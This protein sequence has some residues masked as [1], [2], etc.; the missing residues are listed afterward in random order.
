MSALL[1]ANRSSPEKHDRSTRTKTSEATDVVF[2]D[3]FAI[4]GDKAVMST[5]LDPGARDEADCQGASDAVVDVA[6]ASR[7]GGACRLPGAGLPCRLTGR[8]HPDPASPLRGDVPAGAEPAGRVYANRLSAALVDRSPCRLESHVAGHTL[9]PCRGGKRG[10][11]SARRGSSAGKKETLL[12]ASSPDPAGAMV[13]L[14]VTVPPDFSQADLA[15]ATPSD[16]KEME[17]AL[18]KQ[19][20]KLEGSGGPTII[21]MQRARFETMGGRRALVI[22]YRRSSLAGPSPG[23]SFNQDPPLGSA[24]RADALTPGIRRRGVA[25]RPREGQA[26]IKS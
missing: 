8:R 2:G 20:R 11:R 9:E 10:D 6:F 24:D 17:D 4:S 22:S 16:L 1:I 21:E 23:R 19:Y 7:R 5:R 15:S 13:R 3:S 12:A 26:L 25:T 14:G 18:L